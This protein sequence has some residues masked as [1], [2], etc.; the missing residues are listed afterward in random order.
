MISNLESQ[1]RDQGKIDL[2]PE[3]LDEIP[4]VRA[5]AGYPPLVTPTSQIIGSQAAFN[6]MLGTPYKQ[7][8]MAFRDLLTGKYGRLPGPV[9]PEVMSKAAGDTKPFRERPADLIPDAN[10]NAL[11]QRHGGLIRSHR[12][13]LLLLLFPQPAREVPR[14]EG[15]GPRSRSRRGLT[16]VRAALRFGHGGHGGTEV[17]EKTLRWQRLVLPR[18]LAS[19]RGSSRS[20]RSRALF[21]ARESVAPDLPDADEAGDLQERSFHQKRLTASSAPSVPLCPPVRQESLFFLVG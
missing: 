8:S 11:L 18:T 17:T 21:E 7:V 2:L 20:R 6:V 9:D 16:A 10:F 13:L 5:A 15:E 3:I 1:L 19:M 4:R 12:D 14:A